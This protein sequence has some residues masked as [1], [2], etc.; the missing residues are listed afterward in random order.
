MKRMPWVC[1]LVFGLILSWT[2]AYA[3]DSYVIPVQ[4]CCTCKGTLVGTRWCDN[5]DGTVTDLTTCLVWLKKADWGGS[6]KWEDCSTHNDA[7]TRAGVL[8]A[9]AT[10]A[11]LDDG[12]VVG[13]W[14][15][16]TKTEL[17]G[18]ANGREAV[19][20]GTPR[21]FTGV[22]SGFYW[23][24]TTDAAYTD[25]AYSVLLENGGEFGSMKSNALYVWPVRAGKTGS[26]LNLD[27]KANGQDGPI[28]VT[29]SDPVSIEISLNPGHKAGE[30]A[31]WW[32]VAHTPF[33]PPSDWYSYVYPAGWMPGINL[34]VQTPLFDLSPYEVLDMTLPVGNY[35][36][37]FGIDDP[38]GAATGP[39]WGLDSVEVTVQ[40]ETG[41]QTRGKGDL[42]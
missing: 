12:S 2:L 28:T 32:I 13:D 1:M 27:I 10:D 9:G 3:G 31:D 18:L 33:A 15:L 4:E 30:N 23:S 22:Q 8:Y 36:F 24:S 34:C 42:K 39:W 35:I 40:E 38:D 41:G 5:G 29:P 16:P 26:V 17:Y 25:W 21:G 6:R 19:R 7:Q 11:G 20:S 37:Y 14:R